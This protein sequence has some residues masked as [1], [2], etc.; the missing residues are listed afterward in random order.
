MPAWDERWYPYGEK[1]FE[2]RYRC[3]SMQGGIP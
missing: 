1:V 2:R 3:P